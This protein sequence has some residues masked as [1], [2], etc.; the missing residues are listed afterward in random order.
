MPSPIELEQSARPFDSDS[1]N[2][3]I[4]WELL[5][6]HSAISSR[7]IM[8]KWAEFLNQF[9][10]SQRLFQTPDWL[11][12]IDK[13]SRPDER[14][15]IA[16]ARRDG[17]LIGLVPLH[18]AEDS[19]EFR[20]AG[21]TF[22]R[23]TVMKLST[24][25]GSPL[26]PEVNCLYDS[27]LATLKTNYPKFDGLALSPVMRGSFLWN[28]VQDSVELRKTYLPQVVDGSRLS[29]SMELPPFFSDYLAK[30]RRKKRYNRGREVR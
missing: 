22:Y 19:L 14:V 30:L 7:E 9:G 2:N 28:Y 12:E 11:S 23:S 1:I 20:T 18:L 4:V 17:I 16:L 8:N 29:Y 3:E 21:R 13:Q 10:T 15:A 26:L 5:A 25:G 24:L 6:V 27:L